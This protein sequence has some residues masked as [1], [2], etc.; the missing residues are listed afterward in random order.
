MR[1]IA[2]AV[3]IVALAVAASS[4]DSRA[5]RRPEIPVITLNEL[6]AAPVTTKARKHH[7]ARKHRK[8]AKKRRP[9]VRKHR[10]SARAFRSSGGGVG[11]AP[12]PPPPALPAGHGDD[13]GGGGDDGYDVGDD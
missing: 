3:A 10:G 13:D 1:Y 7:K 6:A 4:Y 9:A 5:P 2:L 12:A 11:A 8:A